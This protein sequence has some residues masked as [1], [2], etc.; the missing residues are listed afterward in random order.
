MWI[1]SSV[2]LDR[3]WICDFDVQNGFDDVANTSIF[4]SV[5]FSWLVNTLLFFLLIKKK[6]QK[7]LC[8]NNALH[9]CVGKWN[10][11]ESKSRPIGRTLSKGAFFFNRTLDT[12]IG[13]QVRSHGGMGNRRQWFLIIL[14]PLT[15]DSKLYVFQSSATLIL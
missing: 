15:I 1:K 7:I 5:R 11:N 9:Q 6:L 2:W 8:N 3:S 14:F 13:K 10:E 12:M 4:K